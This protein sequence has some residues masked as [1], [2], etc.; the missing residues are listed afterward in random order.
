MLKFLHSPLYLLSMLNVKI[1]AFSFQLFFFTF[2]CFRCSKS[3]CFQFNFRC[4]TSINLLF[5]LK[6]KSFYLIPISYF[7]CFQNKIHFLWFQ[8]PPTSSPF[9]LNWLILLFDGCSIYFLLFCSNYLRFEFFDP[10]MIVV[11]EFFDS[12][13]EF[14]ITEIIA[15]E[16]PL[17]NIKVFF[18]LLTVCVGFWIFLYVT[19][20]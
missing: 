11:Q 3:S 6:I 19:L 13:L 17:W 14:L 15:I 1:F 8:F 20:L 7:I 2:N 5:A 9:F 4:L 18:H 16:M 10:F 12:R